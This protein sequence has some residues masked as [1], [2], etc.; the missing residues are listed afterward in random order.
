MT[1]APTIRRVAIPRLGEPRFASPLALDVEPGGARGRF[2]GDDVWVRQCVE[3]D[4][5]RP[6]AEELLLEKAGPRQRIFFDPPGTRAAVVTCGGLCPG[7]N[8]VIRS[9]FLELHFNYGVREVLG[10][11][12]GYQGLVPGAGPPPVPLTLDLVGETHKEGGT[13]LG[14]S[15]GPHDLAVMVGF[16]ESELI[17]ILFCVGGDGTLRGALALGEEL[18]RRGR[19]VSVVGVPKTIDN[20]VAYCDRTFGFHTAVDVA[21]QVIHLAHTEA[22]STP[23][24]VG[25]VKLMGRHAGF[26]ACTATLAS[27]DA[28][29]VLIPESPFTLE[30]PGGLL[31]ALERRV[32]DR[33][34][35]VVVVAEG[36]GQDLFAPSGDGDAGTHDPSGNLRLHDI[37]RRLS[38]EITDHFTKLGRPVDLKYIDPSYIIRSVPPTTGDQLL[39]DDLARRAVH[40]GM[41]GRTGLMI[42]YLNHAFVHVPIPMA[43]SGRRQVDLTGELWSS[44][45]ASTG[46]PPRFAG[47]T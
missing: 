45:L 31:E 10:L 3:V 29:I 18:G 11:R 41:S 21:R 44:V 26:I 36:A 4:D 40:A 38:Q 28:N 47:R 25:L 13:L 12:N 32:D 22:R 30:G 6:P 2:V 33:G 15:R 35:A 1:P 43:V 34:H 24:G 9:L 37:G 20:D 17:D 8:S 23:R 5:A 7:L 46:Q 19:T 39:C 42:G 27:Q 16:L 14:T